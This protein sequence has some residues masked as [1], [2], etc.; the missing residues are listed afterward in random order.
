MIK[1]PHVQNFNAREIFA[2]TVHAFYT[3]YTNASMHI[4]CYRNMME[5][6]N[7]AFVSLFF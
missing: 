4:E 7:S 5:E 2:I 3:V 1:I 6:K